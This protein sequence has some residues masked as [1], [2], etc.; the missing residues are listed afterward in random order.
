MPIVDDVLKYLTKN[1]NIKISKK[2][3]DLVIEKFYPEIKDKIY[4]CCH[5]DYSGFYEGIISKE[6]YEKIKTLPLD[7]N[8]T[9]EQ[10][11]KYEDNECYLEE[12]E[13]SD[14]IDKIKK[15]IDKGFKECTTYFNLMNYLYENENL[16]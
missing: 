10:I 8:I 5:C 7:T 13:F 11:T 2:N 6:E 16:K 4:W 14:E 1:L 9:F 12:I 3:K 15:L